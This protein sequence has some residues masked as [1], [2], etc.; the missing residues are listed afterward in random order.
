MSIRSSHDCGEHR[1]MVWA[2]LFQGTRTQRSS[3]SLVGFLFELVRFF[4]PTDI[5]RSETFECLK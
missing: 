2:E 5:R 4:V 3:K 1:D